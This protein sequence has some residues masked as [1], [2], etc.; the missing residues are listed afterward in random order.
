MYLPKLRE[1]KEAL[2]SFF[3]APYTTRFPAED[4]VPVPEYRGFPEYDAE[5]CVGCGT[6]AQVCPTGAIIL[7]DDK[8]KKVRTL[9]VEYCSCIHCGQCHEKCITGEGIN[10][11]VKYALPVMDLQAPE[12][13]ETLEKEL[14]VC[15]ACGAVIA[16]AD[17]LGWI[18]R[19]LGAKAYANPLLMMEL[20]DEIFEAET[21]SVKS[22]IRREDYM[23]ITCAKCRQKI[24]TADEFYGFSN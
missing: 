11:T 8:V 17:H 4:Y 10:P 24:V 2:T 9:T 12:L 7:R 6:C 22:R 14:A 19:R 18:R 3:T 1:L 21:S 16:C 20:Q 5:K 23:K 13:F 15:E